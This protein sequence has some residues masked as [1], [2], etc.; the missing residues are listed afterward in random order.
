MYKYYNRNPRGNLTAGDCVIR[1][2]SI[3]TGDSWDDIYD[4]LCAEGKY[5]G[6]WGSNNGVWD[7]YLRQRGFKRYACP[8]TCS[9][10]YSVADFAREHPYGAYILAT[11]THAI[12]VVDGDYIDASDSGQL[13][14]LYFYTKEV[15]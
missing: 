14:P 10:C 13:S 8:S 11:G 15:I 5:L 3:V 1:A 6:D 7:S 4:D 12:A 2:I 9:Y